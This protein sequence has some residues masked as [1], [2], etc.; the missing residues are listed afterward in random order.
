MPAGAPAPLRMARGFDLRP[1]GVRWPGVAEDY[2][3]FR[4][5]PWARAA[6]RP[7]RR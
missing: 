6:D 7:R 2:R 3:V 5:Q 1:A 4:E